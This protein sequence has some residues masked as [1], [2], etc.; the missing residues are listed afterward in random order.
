MTPLSDTYISETLADSPLIFDRGKQTCKNGSYFL[1]H[2]DKNSFVYEFDGTFGYYTSRL[3]FWD[4][5][6]EA[7]CTCPYPGKGCRHVVAAALNARD[8]ILKPK[9]EQDLFAASTDIYLSHAQVREQAL[10]E[11]QDKSTDTFTPIRGDM[12]TGDHKVVSKDK[13]TYT[14]CFHDPLQ[15]KGHCSC[16]DYLT[17][18]LG[19]CIIHGKI[20]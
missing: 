4:D 9:I 16:P 7:S 12:F 2:R 13:R 18:G 14:V 15:G 10:K 5:K 19:T 1:S 20:S 8:I 3:Q 17:N 11:R 6:I